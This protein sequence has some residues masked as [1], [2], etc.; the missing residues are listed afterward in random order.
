MTFILKA[1]LKFYKCCPITFKVWVGGSIPFMCVKMQGIILENDSMQVSNM[2]NTNTD[3]T[4]ATWA[5]KE[6]TL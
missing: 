4:N 6:T 2:M 1:K 5:K 3:K